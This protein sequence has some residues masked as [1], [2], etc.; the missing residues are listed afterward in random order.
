[1]TI[2]HDVFGDV[3]GLETVDPNAV[4]DEARRH[5]Y[6]RGEANIL[7]A[8]AQ[9]KQQNLPL[10]LDK[11]IFGGHSNGGD[12]VKYFVNQ[13]PALVRSLILFDARRARLKPKAP[14]PVL[15]FE[16]D[17]TT[18]DIG[19]IPDPVEENNSIRS[20]LD[21]TI[22]KPSGALHESYMDDYITGEL[23]NRVFS[24]LD[25]FLENRI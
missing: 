18:T 12:I 25:W 4:Q 1:M 21:L 6:I 22:I 19:V 16:A 23:K 14:L 24:A 20:N 7:F 9:L 2:Q 8:I 13:H 11:F 15:M 10:N 5:L 3:D 17:D